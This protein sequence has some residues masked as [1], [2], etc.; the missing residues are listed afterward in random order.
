MPSIRRSRPP[1]LR[2][3]PTAAERPPY[4]PRYVSWLVAEHGITNLESHRNHY[5]TVC[6]SLLTSFCTSP[7]WQALIHALPNIDVEYNIATQFPLIVTFEPHVLTKPW[8]SFFEKTYRKNIAENDKF[9][10]QPTEG[11]CIPPSWYSQIHDIIRTTII[12]K[13]IDGVPLVLRHLQT[14]AT[15]RNCTFEAKLETRDDG[16]YGAHFNLRMAC[17]IYTMEWLQENRIV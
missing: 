15:G 5:D 13:Y 8:N 11:W 6:K 2:R 3:K 16:Y 10:R 1:I 17:D 4:G 9:P 12:V 7:F 14:L